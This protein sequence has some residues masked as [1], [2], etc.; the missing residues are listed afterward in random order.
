M[1]VARF[2]EMRSPLRATGLSSR[3]LWIGLG[4]FFLVGHSWMWPSLG[5]PN[6]RTRIYL[7]VALVDEGTVAIDG[8]MA[9]FGKMGDRARF[10]DRALTDKA[11]GSSFIAA[12]P[13]AVARIFTAPEDWTITGL[14]GL[15]RTWVMLPIALLGFLAMRRILLLL[16]DDAHVADL[17]AVGWLL[18]TSAFHY[19]G[20][21]YGHHI[22]AVMLLVAL[23]QLLEAERTDDRWWRCAIA[24]GCAGLAGLTEYQ[25]GGVC[26]M[27]LVWVVSG[28]GRNLRRLLIFGATAAPAVVAL[29]VYNTVAFGGPLELSY[30]HL[31]LPQFER[32]HGHGIGGVT[33]PSVKRLPW[34][35]FSLHRG[36]LVTSPIFLLG[37]PGIYLLWRRGERRLALRVPATKSW[38]LILAAALFYL[39]IITGARAWFGGWSFGLRLMLPVFPLLL[40]AAMAPMG[41]LRTHAAPELLTRALFAVGLLYQQVVHA[42]LPELPLRARNPIIDVV[43]PSLGVGLFVPNRVTALTGVDDALWTLLPLALVTC[44]WFGW[45]TRPRGPW[46]AID[47]PRRRRHLLAGVAAGLALVGVLASLVLMRGQALTDERQQVTIEFFEGQREKTRALRV[48]EAEHRALRSTMP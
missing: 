41:L 39:A 30:Q 26:L 22:V 7:T 15:M 48:R 43:L 34:V 14:I 45:I 38:R 27:L 16:F 47:G 3:M 37:L 21:F 46:V 2:I 12:V 23:W 42:V 25:A 29:L 8:P 35:L 36:L 40:L 13:Y 10:G 44:A 19:A 17:G 24:G 32:F 4:L 20:T 31:A 9:R 28:P 11:P 18:A 1:R 33:L 5:L 6:E